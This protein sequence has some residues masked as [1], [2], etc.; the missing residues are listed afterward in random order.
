MTRVL[1]EFRARRRRRSPAN[2]QRLGVELTEREWDVLALLR[3]DLSTAEIAERLAISPV[4]V[5]RHVSELLRKLGVPSRA[6][7]VALVDNSV[8]D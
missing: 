6:D 5:R 2:L 3:R 8:Q 1:H 4:T 7:A